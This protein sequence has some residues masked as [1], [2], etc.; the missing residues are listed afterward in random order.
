MFPGRGALSE[1]EFL[2][3]VI[4]YPTKAQRANIGG[5]VIVEFVINSD[6]SASDYKIINSAGYGCNEEALRVIKFV[7]KWEPKVV[8]GEKISSVF[9]QGITFV[10]SE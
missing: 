2:Q 9:A 4:K 5:K 3:R 1:D 7:Y 10:V 8:N 6:G